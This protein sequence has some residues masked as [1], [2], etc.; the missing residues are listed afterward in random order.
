ME[1]NKHK[2]KGFPPGRWQCQGAS[3]KREELCARISYPGGLAHFLND[4]PRQVRSPTRDR[5]EVMLAIT[6]KDKQGVPNEGLLDTS[7]TRTRG[8]TAS[9]LL[10]IR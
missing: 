9:F 2:K 8:T 10:H 6:P 4:D 3:E 7:E 5:V 1:R